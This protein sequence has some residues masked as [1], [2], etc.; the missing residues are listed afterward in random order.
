[1]T[2]GIKSVQQSFACIVD[3][4]LVISQ[5]RE[6]RKIL[7]QSMFLNLEFLGSWLACDNGG[8]RMEIEIMLPQR[9][10]FSRFSPLRPLLIPPS[11]FVY[12]YAA[13]KYQSSHTTP[14]HKI[15]P[16]THTH[17]YIS[18]CLF[19]NWTNETKRYR[20]W[21]AH[22]LTHSLTHCKMLWIIHQLW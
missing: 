5:E 8:F 9:N 2:K 16:H 15:L 20:H 19:R 18:L 11:L 22:S 17:I 1:M 6:K 14:Y 10:D 3:R 7:R 13:L 12:P 4:R 21:P